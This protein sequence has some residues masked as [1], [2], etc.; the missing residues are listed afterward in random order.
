M[1]CAEL[2]RLICCLC[3]QLM[4][5]IVALELAEAVVGSV[6]DAAFRPARVTRVRVP[7]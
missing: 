4:P 1:T 6:R 2:H 3:L 7:R 5:G